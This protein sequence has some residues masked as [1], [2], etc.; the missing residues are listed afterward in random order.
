MAVAARLL[1]AVCD[2]PD[3]ETKQFVKYAKKGYTC[4]AQEAK[5]PHR[6][7]LHLVVRLL[8]LRAEEHNKSFDQ[9]RGTTRLTRRRWGN[10][11]DAVCYG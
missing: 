5:A 1:T 4:D 7:L 3:D 8:L 2:E 6:T 11:S 10:T 9:G